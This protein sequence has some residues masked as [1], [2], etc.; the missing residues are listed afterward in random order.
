M[1]RHKPSV[2]DA[3]SAQGLIVLAQQVSSLLAVK[4]VEILRLRTAL[5]R[6]ADNPSWTCAASVQFIREV[7]EEG[8]DLASSTSD[9]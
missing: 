8:T 4:D 9:M 5:E 3:H 6:I 1:P 2:P 7:L